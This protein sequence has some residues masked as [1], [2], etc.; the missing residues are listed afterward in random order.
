MLYVFR[1]EDVCVHNYPYDE[2]TPSW[3]LKRRKC[4][5]EK[6]K[7]S[8]RQKTRAL[9][10]NQ[11]YT[12]GTASFLDPQS[13]VSDSDSDSLTTLESRASSSFSSI[14]GSTSSSSSGSTSGYTSDNES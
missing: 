13:L 6:N 3:D 4:V 8:Q 12:D 10:T 5:N 7:T 9:P 2:V 1:R 14:S 11:L